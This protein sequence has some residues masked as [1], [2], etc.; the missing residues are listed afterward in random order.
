MLRPPILFSCAGGCFGCLG[1]YSCCS[2]N[3]YR[4]QV[5]FVYFSAVVYV[6]DASDKVRIDEA[7]FELHELLKSR[8]LIKVPLV[9][10]ANKQDTEGNTR[11]QIRLQ[12]YRRHCQ[13]H[14]LIFFK[15]TSETNN[16]MCC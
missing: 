15:I 13:S 9:V 7:K 5:V 10:V 2:S 12:S 4:M 14:K 16:M 3:M 1:C 11:I 6:V 8:D